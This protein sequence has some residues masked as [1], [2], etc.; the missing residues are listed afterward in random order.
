MFIKTNSSIY[1]DKVYIS[2]LLCES[3]WENGVSKTRIILNISKLPTKQQLAIEQSIKDCGPKVHIGD[4]AVEKSID[5]GWVAIILEIL[6]R[7]R[8]EETLQK[9]YPEN[10]KLVHRPISFATQFGI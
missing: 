3:Y 1:K 8:I 9:V 6:K 4:I 5:Y 7:L 2:K 10:F